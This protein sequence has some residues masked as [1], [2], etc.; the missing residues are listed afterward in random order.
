MARFLPQINEVVRSDEMLAQRWLPQWEKLAE[1]S[2]AS[3]LEEA[4]EGRRAT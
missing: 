4:V 3:A 1:R 2:W